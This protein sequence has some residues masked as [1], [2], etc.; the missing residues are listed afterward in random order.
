MDKSLEPPTPVENVDKLDKKT[1][2]SVH[3]VE[4]YQQ[5]YQVDRCN[6]GL[7]YQIVTRKD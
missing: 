3:V 1:K 6:S 2:N 4:D 7:D 5:V